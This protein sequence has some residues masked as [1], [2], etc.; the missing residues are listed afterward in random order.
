MKTIAVFDTSICSPNLGDRII[1]DSVVRVLE[2]IFD[3]ALF[4]NFQT[5]DTLGKVSYKYLSGTDL[6][7]VGGTNLL[8][9]NMNSYNQ[10]KVTL[11]DSIYIN[12]LILMGVGWW[13]Y[14]K[15]PNWYTKVLYQKI[16]SNKYFHSVRDNYTKKQL[17]S[18]GIN[19]VINTSC[20]TM[21]RL[22][23]EHCTDIPRKKSDRVIVTFTEY[24]QNKDCDQKMFDILRNN[25]DEIYFWTQQPKD[26]E[27]MY[28]IGQDKVKYVNPSLGALDAALELEI[29]YVGTRLHAGI[30]ALQHQK[31]GLI[32]AVD[33]RAREIG[34]DTGLPTVDRDD[35]QG[36]K[37]WI[38]SK[39]ET[40]ISIPHENIQ[41][42]KKQFM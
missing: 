6:K 30:R 28:Q 25:Y 33:N 11:L 2:E 13:Q 37:D 5:H 12:D 40:K 31:R 39:A 35:F 9:S 14:Q 27:Y 29:D 1:M 18:I 3:S 32:L 16:L 22:T 24:S 41:K 26:Y 21:W 36:I 7:I 38:H 19:N 8:S 23:E 4:I 17:E 20:P 42:W 10:W 15:K 34:K